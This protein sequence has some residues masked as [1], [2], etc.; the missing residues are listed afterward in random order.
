MI[1][2]IS[3]HRD[4]RVVDYSN[5]RY[6]ENYGTFEPRSGV[7]LF[8]SADFHIKYVGKA[9]PG[10]MVAEIESAI[11]R[12]KN[13]GATRVKALYTNSDERA[14]SLEAYLIDKYAP[15]NNLT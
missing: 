12:G 3:D 5:W 7:Y 15:P 6:L 13:Y 10:R 1:W 2:G 8:A 9:G 4:Y 11:S 14:S